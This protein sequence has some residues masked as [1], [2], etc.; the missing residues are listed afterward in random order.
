MYENLVE[1][2]E[3]KEIEAEKGAHF[4]AFAASTPRSRDS[5]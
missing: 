3:A 5:N 2:G 4:Y 1:P